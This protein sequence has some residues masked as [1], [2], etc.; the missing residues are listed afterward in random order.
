MSRVECRVSR[1]KRIGEIK[2]S[3]FSSSAHQCKQSNRIF[4]M[5]GARSNRAEVPRGF[6]D[7][8]SNV[9][10]V[11]S[12]LDRTERIAKKIIRASS[13]GDRRRLDVIHIRSIRRMTVPR[14]CA[15]SRSRARD[16][17]FL[18]QPT[19]RKATTFDRAR[20]SRSSLAAA[21]ERTGAL[22][23]EL[24]A[25]DTPSVRK[26]A[27]INSYG[28]SINH[29]LIRILLLSSRRKV[30]RRAS[31]E[32]RRSVLAAGCPRIVRESL[33]SSHRSFSS[34]TRVEG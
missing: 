5:K 29:E 32:T 27:R 10:R 16:Q 20:A 17:T 7:A 8:L 25:L 21:N 26:L 6:S 18:F 15:P 34:V 19:H 22:L 12:P 14:R 2:P 4:P 1:S 11:A 24:L 33:H 23:D 9:S 13:R 3:L 28:R 31:I 30:A